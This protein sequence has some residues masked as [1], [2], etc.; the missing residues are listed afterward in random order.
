[1]PIHVVTDVAAYATLDPGASAVLTLSLQFDSRGPEPALPAGRYQLAIP[2]TNPHDR[3]SGPTASASF[4]LEGLDEDEARS[5]AQRVAFATE[6]G[7]AHTSELGQRALA[8]TAPEAIALSAMDAPGVP[9]MRAR[10]A[11]FLVRFPEAQERLRSALRGSSF[12]TAVAVNALLSVRA[13]PPTEVREEALRAL[14]SALDVSGFDPILVQAVANSDSRAS[15]LRAVAWRVA[16]RQGAELGPWAAGLAC[17]RARVGDEL[18]FA[19]LIHAFRLRAQKA[20]PELAV[21]LRD[22]ADAFEAQLRERRDEIDQAL[23]IAR[24]GRPPSDGH[25]APNIGTGC[26][27]GTSGPRPEPACAGAEITPKDPALRFLSAPMMSGG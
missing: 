6:H 21:A 3:S 10:Y 2:T 11:R 8:W 19:D 4:R 22:R 5:L 7:C 27:Y 15:I 16:G 1:M 17:A 12:D 26:G 14:P 23:R 24:A 18:P 25:H 20:K 9:W 13:Q